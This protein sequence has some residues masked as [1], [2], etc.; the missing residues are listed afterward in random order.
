MKL[1]AYFKPFIHAGLLMFSIVLLSGCSTINQLT[2]MQKPEA[3][4]QNVSIAGLSFDAINLLFDIDVRNPNSLGIKLN[5]FDYDMQ[6]NG[7][8]FLSGI[9]DNG[10]EIAANGQKTV[11]LPLT[12]KFAD[13]YKT[14]TGLKEKDST[15]YQLKAGFAFDV[16]IIGS[17]RVP[18]NKSGSLPNLKLPKISIGSLKLARLSLSGADLELTIDIDNPNVFGINLND[19]AYTFNVNGRTWGTGQADQLLSVSEKGKGALKLPISLN[20]LEMGMGLYSIIN[21]DEDLSYSFDS[22]V[23]FGSTLSLLGNTKLRFDKTGKLKIER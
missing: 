22:D 8:S 23:N 4:V 17:V 13:L 3:K 21:G 5:Q 9:N 14:F 18:V 20:F 19:L 11:Q 7:N 12:L 16:P 6:I 10:L 1:K 15:S 2:K